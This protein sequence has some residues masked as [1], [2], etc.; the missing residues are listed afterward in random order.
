M[1]DSPIFGDISLYAN[2]FSYM[3][4]RLTRELTDDI[5]AVV[6]GIPYDMATTGRP[7]TRF[8][9][10]GVRQ[11]SVSLRWE[12]ARWPWRFVLFDRLQVVDYGDVDFQPGN[13]AD[14]VKRVQ[15]DAGR[16]LAAGKKLVSFGGD[17]FVTLPLLR[18]AHKV[19]GKM[20]LIHF[21]A[22]TDT[23]ADGS[24]YDHGTMFYHAP[25]ERLIDTEHSIQVGIRTEYGYDDHPF[26][27]IDAA[28]ANDLQA[29]QIVQQIKAR[30]G[31]LPVYLTFDIDCLDPAYAPG[32]GTPVIGGLTSDLAL[33]IIRG[34]AGVNIVAADVVEVAPCYDQSDITALAG[35][36]LA[37]E[38]LHL[39]V[40]E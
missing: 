26:A 6:L 7:G 13:D 30:V 24:E 20:A 22:H 23:Y 21:D 25:K 28:T 5:D 4:R 2:N 12:E 37:L 36:T 40:S 34:L 8:G 15:H 31:D 3:G 29:E 18:A 33:K 19:H 16:I 38:M 11:A 27:V 9:P 14:M 35:A 32:T 17:H 39:F 10:N 1:S